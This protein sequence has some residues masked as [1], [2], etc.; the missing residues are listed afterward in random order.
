MEKAY[1]N[2]VEELGQS[3]LKLQKS[4]TR[5]LGFTQTL[6]YQG[7]LFRVSE[8]CLIADL[9]PIAYVDMA[10]K[11]IEGDTAAAVLSFYERLAPLLECRHR[12]RPLSPTSS[13]HFSSL[14]CGVRDGTIIYVCTLCTGYGHAS[15]SNT[16]PQIGNRLA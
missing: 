5:A 2:T 16:L 13:P 1:I 8:H 14:S 10:E 15:D 9:S 11:I 7:I 4:L 3:L 12:W 6:E